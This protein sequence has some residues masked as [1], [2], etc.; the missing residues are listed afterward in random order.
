MRYTMQKAQRLILVHKVYE[1]LLVLKHR[2]YV[3]CR[4][5]S[6]TPLHNC[7]LNILPLHCVTLLQGHH[8]KLSL[9]LLSFYTMVQFPC[10]Q[11]WLICPSTPNHSQ[12][13]ILECAQQSEVVT[14]VCYW[15]LA[16]IRNEFIWVQAANVYFDPFDTLILTPF[17]LGSHSLQAKI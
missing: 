3:P 7:N 15:A 5:H 13:S 9:S 16:L 8:C 12:G 2:K 1:G 11:Q 4:A 6:L 17:F 14:Y 10:T